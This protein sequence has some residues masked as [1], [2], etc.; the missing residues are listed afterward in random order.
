MER[1]KSNI[2]PEIF[3]HDSITMKIRKTIQCFLCT[4]SQH[5]QRHWHL[6]LQPCEQGTTSN[7]LRQ[8]LPLKLEAF[9][10]RKMHIILIGSFQINPLPQL[11]A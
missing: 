8:D 4:V 9:I 3:M 1:K 10:N 2:Y 6:A 7:V 5:V 11:M